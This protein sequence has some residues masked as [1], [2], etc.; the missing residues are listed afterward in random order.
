MNMTRNQMKKQ[1]N[2]STAFF[3]ESLVFVVVTRDIVEVLSQIID[4]ASW[5]LVGEED[6]PLTVAFGAVENGF[7]ATATQ[8]TPNAFDATRQHW[9]S[10][11]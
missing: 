7:V 5:P 9:R 3:V 1:P 4:R 6:D 10:R 2:L 8:D 11:R